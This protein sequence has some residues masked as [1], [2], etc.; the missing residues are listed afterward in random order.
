MKKV[1]G[2]TVVALLSL[3]SLSA[4][5]LTTT[6]VTPSDLL[7][8]RQIIYYISADDIEQGRHAKLRP[9][10]I[11]E[12]KA[13]SAYFDDKTLDDLKDMTDDEIADMILDEA[14]RNYVR[15]FSWYAKRD[16][17]KY[18]GFTID[19]IVQVTNDS[20]QT[21]SGL[22]NDDYDGL[23]RDQCSSFYDDYAPVG[24]VWSNSAKTV[25]DVQSEISN[26]C[27]T[28]LTTA[29]TIDG[30]LKTVGLAMECVV[31]EHGTYSNACDF[32][33]ISLLEIY[34]ENKVFPI[35]REHPEK[36]MVPVSVSL[37]MDN[38]G[39]KVGWEALVETVDEK[40]EA[41]E[42]SGE[43]AMFMNAETAVNP[44]DGQD[45]DSIRGLEVY[46]SFYRFAWSDESGSFYYMIRYPSKE[47]SSKIIFA[48]DSA[49][50]EG[51]EVY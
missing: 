25:A 15:N 14:A 34:T 37:S 40:Q 19:D 23:S 50:L 44:I 32:N 11:D 1:I 42:Y 24:V 41:E 6:E 35:V 30:I 4:C 45:S 22:L 38:T 7:E 18:L 9:T 39:N 29:Q 31:D 16:G 28:S 36:L 33:F 27:G 48:L 8:G 10:L 13:V 2:A 20:S 26:Y 46:D 12:G 47:D 5:S 43:P 51:A 21:E 3:M 17:L 49:D